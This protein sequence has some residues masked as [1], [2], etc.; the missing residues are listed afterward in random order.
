MKPNEHSRTFYTFSVL[1]ITGTYS[2]SLNA[3]TVHLNKIIS[4]M[5]VTNK[6]CLVCKNQ[7]QFGG[8]CCIEET[9]ND[10]WGR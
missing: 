3:S 8:K 4:S 6:V 5:L 10:C 7:D 1:I 2:L 9:E